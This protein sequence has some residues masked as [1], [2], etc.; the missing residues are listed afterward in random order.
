MP[1]TTHAPPIRFHIYRRAQRIGRKKARLEGKCV[2]AR[3]EMIELPKSHKSFVDRGS[4]ADGHP[5]KR[6]VMTLEWLKEFAASYHDGTQHFESHIEII[7][8]FLSRR[9]VT[10][11]AGTLVNVRVR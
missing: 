6:L 8:K 9:V 1:C 7:Q 3:S 10:E 5:P 11:N 4:M 2:T